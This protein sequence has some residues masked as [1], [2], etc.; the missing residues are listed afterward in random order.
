VQCFAVISAMALPTVI[1]ALIIEGDRNTAN[2]LACY[3]SGT[4]ALI[5][6]ERSLSLWSA[7]SAA[8]T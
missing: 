7:S 3:A 1:S 2:D 8:T 5:G 4:V 6:A